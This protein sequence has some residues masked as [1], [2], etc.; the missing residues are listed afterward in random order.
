MG[1]RQL[2]AATFGRAQHHRHPRL[3][4][5]HIVDLGRVIDHLVDRQQAEV[6]RHDFDY[7]S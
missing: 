4:A 1:C 3:A 7:R 5:K 6:D 2:L